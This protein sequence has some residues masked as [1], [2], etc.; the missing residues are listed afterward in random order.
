MGLDESTFEF[1]WDQFQE[2]H[3]NE[4][5]FVFSRINTDAANKWQCLERVGFRLVD[6]NVQFELNGRVV[7]NKKSKNEFVIC[8]AEKKYQKAVAVTNSVSFP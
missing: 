3:R 2:E 4:Q 1:N 7:V 5:Y 6:T 8:F